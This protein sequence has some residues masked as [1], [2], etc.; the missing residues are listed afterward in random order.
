VGHAAQPVTLSAFARVNVYSFQVDHVWSLGKNVRLKDQTPSSLPH[1]HAI[2]LN[3]ASDALAKPD[4]ISF[5]WINA[6]LGEHHSGID[7]GDGG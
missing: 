4:S 6:A 2:V 1:I 7:S 5:K 3:P